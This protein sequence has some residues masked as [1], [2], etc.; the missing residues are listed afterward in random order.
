MGNSVGKEGQML[1]RHFLGLSFSAGLAAVAGSAACSENYPNKPLRIIAAAPGGG[2]DFVARV[3]ANGVSGPLGQPVIVENRANAVVAASMAAKAPSDGYTFHVAGRVLWISSLLQE[4][5]YDP[6]KDFSPIS[7]LVREVFIVAVHPSV[8]ANSIKELIALAKAKPGALNYASAGTGGPTHIA[9]EL[10]KSMAGIDI[11]RVAYKGNAAAV[12]AL[13]TGEVQMTMLDAGLLAPHVKAGKLKA[14]AVS[15]AE[16]SALVPGLPTVAASGLPGFEAVGVTV[17]LAP[18]K[19]PPSIINRLNQEI[20]RV[21]LR[22]EIK[23]QFLARGAEVVAST[24]EQFSAF[25]KLD[26]ARTGKVIK[27]AG[28][29]SD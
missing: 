27:D 5:P 20:R 28:I 4:V 21:L 3:V 29:K 14:L 16:P 1:L 7:L 25:I 11:V 24:P 12:T 18:G 23:E 13:L 2:S 19:T 9:V 17:I 26:I 10:F 6:L 15:S 22:P 8:T